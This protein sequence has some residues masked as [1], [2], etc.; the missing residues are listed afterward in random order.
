MK[1]YIFC[2][3]TIISFFLISCGGNTVQSQDASNDSSSDI[4]VSSISSKK[5]CVLD[6]LE[7]LCSILLEDYITPF[8]NGKEIIRDNQNFKESQNFMN[9]CRFS[10][11]GEGTRDMK[12]SNMI[13]KVPNKCEISLYGVKFID[14]DDPV[15]DFNKY[16]KSVT[17]EDMSML[18]EQV[19]KEMDKNED[20]AETS[21]ETGKALGGSLLSELGKS[22]Y[23]DVPG[24]GDAAKW[25]SSSSDMNSPTSGTLF[26]QNGKERFSLSVDVGGSI[27]ASKTAAIEVAKKILAACN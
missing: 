15:G 6:N 26:I 1:N 13:V 19:K 10:W 12:V 21:K 4:P 3:I 25:E 7:D 5:S 14:V 8:G 16:Y 9:F 2:S 23:E 11:D 22:K 27:E 17:E 24:L 18:K 20:L